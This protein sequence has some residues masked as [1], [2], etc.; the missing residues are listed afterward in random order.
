[1]FLGERRRARRPLEVSLFCVGYNGR[2][3]EDISLKKR[4][5]PEPRG[6]EVSSIEKSAVA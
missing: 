1:M 6:R 3:P 2:T 5:A 4:S